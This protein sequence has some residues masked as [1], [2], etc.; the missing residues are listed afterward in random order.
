MRVDLM[1]AIYDNFTELRASLPRPTERHYYGAGQALRDADGIWI[2]AATMGGAGLPSDRLSFPYAQHPT[3]NKAVRAIERNLSAP[4]LE[5]FVGDSDKALPPTHP[6]VQRFAMPDPGSSVRRR[7]FVTRHAQ[8]MELS[9]D[10]FLYLDG[11]ARAGGPR[12]AAFPT[13]MRRLP[14]ERFEP[15][16]SEETGD[17]TGWKYRKPNGGVENFTLEQIVHSFYPSPYSVH[18]GLAPLVAAFLEADS[19][20]QA[21]VGN[22]YMFEN[23]SSRGMIFKATEN[24]G[25]TATQEQRQR[26]LEDWKANRQG[27]TRGYKAA[28]TPLGVD[29]HE[30]G[31]S[32]RD[33]EFIDLRRFSREQILAVFDVPPAVAGVFEYANYANAKEQLRYFWYHKLFPM[34][35]DLEAVIQSDLLDR[36]NTGLRCAFKREMV[37]ALIEDMSVKLDAAKKAWDMGVP[38]ELVNER[39][40]L[41]FD[42]T[43]MDGADVGFLPF[44]VTPVEQ[45]IEPPEPVVAPPAGEPADDEPPAK[46]RAQVAVT[47]GDDRRARRWRG[48]MRQADQPERDMLAAWRGVIQWTGEHA[49]KDL[50]DLQQAVYLGLVRHD[51][52]GAPRILPNDD[53][54][55]SEAMR[56]VRPAHAGAY[57]TGRKTAEADLGVELSPNFLDRRILKANQERAMYIKSAALGEREAVRARIAEGL[58]EGAS[59]DKIEESIRQ[60]MNQAKQGM[61]RTV[62]RTE[63]LSA[64]GRAR[65]D[66][67]GEAGVRKQEWLSAR[68]EDVRPSHQIDGETVMLGSAFSNGLMFPMDPNGP[69]EET[70]QCRCVALPVVE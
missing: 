44:S 18:M 26:F 49:I 1:Q 28:M 45:A 19:D 24:V 10:W 57:R 2:Q 59:I 34:M 42:T 29:V 54:V 33:M 70:I 41:G 4:P 53:E 67:F 50:K 25:A 15:R 64:F 21:A 51:D 66:A 31:Q 20:Y 13:V 58:K 17:L 65:M 11:F 36:F 32:N 35:D 16:V 52:E 62:A 9:G 47:H 68:D 37:Q 46:N 23:D 14:R 5:L 60:H 39:F 63:T 69:P 22:R 8:D 12:A 30:I 43:K 55:M 7:G 61:A 56:R 48:L 38:F 3:V 40:E 27:V 6:I